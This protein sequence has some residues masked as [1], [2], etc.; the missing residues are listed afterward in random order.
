MVKKNCI[1]RH[2]G[3]SGIIMAVAVLALPLLFS[4]CSGPKPSGDTPGQLQP[5]QDELEKLEQQNHSLNRQIEQLQNEKKALQAR[6]DSLY[7]A[8]SADLTGDGMNETITGPPW[9]TPASL[10]ERGGSLKVE[11]ADGNILLDEKSGIL[12][13][14]GMY[15]AGAKTP[16]LITSQWGGGSMGEYYGAYLFDPVLNK[17][18]RLDWDNAPI[19]VGSL[20]NSQCK[21][22]SLVI[23]NRGLESAGG[24]YRPFYQRWIYRNGQMVSVEKWDADNYE[25]PP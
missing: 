2:R 7:S 6:L 10:F 24:G 25:E 22:G 4:A 8:W 1:I 18:K 9:P 20:D 11:S 17:L 3:L 13:V 14:A 12:S 19:A 16:V 15:D 23:K 5:K 21:P